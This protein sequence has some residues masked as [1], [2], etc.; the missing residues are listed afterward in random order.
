MAWLNDKTANSS[1]RAVHVTLPPGSVS[2]GAASLRL[3]VGLNLVLEGQG[4]AG[5]QATTL[6]LD[7]KNLDIGGMLGGSGRIEFRNM[8]ITNVRARSSAPEFRPPLRA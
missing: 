6:N 5:A 3:P 7:K 2:R 8:A 4:M 1:F